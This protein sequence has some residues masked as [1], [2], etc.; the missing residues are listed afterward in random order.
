MARGLSRQLP[1]PPS[2]YAFPPADRGTGREGVLGVGADFAPGTLLAAYRQ[3][4][5]PWPAPSE[6]VVVWCSPN[7]RAIFPLDA[8]PHWSRS[9]RRSMRTKPFRVTIDQAFEEVMTGC[10][11]REEGTWITPELS[12]GY[13]ELFAMGW[14]HSLEVWNTQSGELVG[15]IY[16]LALGAAFTA[17]SMFHR[18]T[19]ASKVAFASLVERLRPD[20]D[21]FDAEIMN[22]HLA[23]LGCVDMPRPEFLGRLA[24]ALERSPEFPKS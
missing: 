4:I 23:S 16:G 11:E 24:D 21:I 7:P 5:F 15:G 8:P 12:L 22:P 6:E 13:R 2:R 1:F 14:A 17:E 3:G 9:L 20:F 10:G 18:E 19:D